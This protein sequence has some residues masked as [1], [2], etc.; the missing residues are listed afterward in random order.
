M[1]ILRRIEK[2]LD[3]RLRGVFR[4]SGAEPGSAEAVELYRDALDQIAARA[5]VGVR[6]DRVFPFDQI[7]VELKAE[8]PE[9]RSVLEALFVPEQML[10]DV[11][12]ALLEAGVTA[13]P[14]LAVTVEFPDSPA[15]ELRVLC[16]KGAT[17][18]APV[19]VAVAL[20]PM[21]LVTLAGIASAPE[22]A[23]ERAH[24]SIGRVDEVL[25][26]LGRAI[27]RNDLYFPEADSEASASVSRAHAHLRLDA[28]TGEWRIYDDGSS[29]G[30]SI[31]REGRRIDVPAHAGRGVMLRAGD[32]IYLGQTRLRFEVVPGR[33]AL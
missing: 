30:T 27:R 21:R 1:S 9:R 10:S 13:L 18:A 3:D 33:K 2:T 12:A 16:E 23:L 5:M 25:D 6:G 19:P 15:V 11:R 7:R 28:V 24:I 20:I 8:T 22:F 4:G 29:L 32:E 31:F 26:S 14:A 17:T